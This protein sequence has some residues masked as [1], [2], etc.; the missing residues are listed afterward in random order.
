[1]TSD[2][3][4]TGRVTDAMRKGAEDFWYGLDHNFGCNGYGKFD[5]EV[6][7][8]DVEAF[9]LAMKQEQASVHSP[10]EVERLTPEEAWQDLV[11]KDDRT[12]PEEYP[13]MCLITRAELT[14]YMNRAALQHPA[15][16]MGK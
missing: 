1:M 11:E 12:S 10:D 13:E 2:N 5:E 9:Y 14:D 4:V 7:N 3:H 15:K 6:W 16:E 8:R